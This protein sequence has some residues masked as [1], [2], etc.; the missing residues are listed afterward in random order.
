[1]SEQKSIGKTI[2]ERLQNFA[3]NLTSGQR[4]RFRIT[5]IE[6]AR[7]V[8]T[9]DIACP[10]CGARESQKNTE[11][12]A[13]DTYLNEG[14]FKQGMQCQINVAQARIATLE[15]LLRRLELEAIANRAIIR[16]DT[17]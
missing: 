14:V 12:W 13:C 1:M 2:L 8:V 3:D 17:E 5:R 10:L 16:K 7:N 15:A 6:V 4:S 11:Y 9:D